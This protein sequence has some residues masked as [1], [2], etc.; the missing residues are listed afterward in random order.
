MDIWTIAMRA[1]S[2]KAMLFYITHNHSI[3]VRAYSG[4]GWET[5]FDLGIHA[6][7]PDSR[8]ISVTSVTDS[9][10]LTANATAD[11]LFLFYES[12][13]GNVTALLATAL[14][15]SGP[16][17]STP[18]R[19]FRVRDISSSKSMALPPY[20]S[21]SG[22]YYYGSEPGLGTVR[23]TGA[24]LYDNRSQRALYDTLPGATFGVPFTSHRLSDNS[25][26]LKIDALFYAPSTSSI[27]STLYNPTRDLDQRMVTGLHQLSIFIFVKRLI[28]SVRYKG[29]S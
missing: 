10:N 11:L 2:E 23:G 19:S 6:T 22:C 16:N 5:G 20:V 9:P 3:N 26:Q 13:G 27:L 17:D 18:C 15:I 14:M 1:D 21:K 7:A 28:F 29:I 12:P 24:T 4:W 8:H 25:S